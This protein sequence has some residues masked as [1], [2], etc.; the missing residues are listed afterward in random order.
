MDTEQTA[1]KGAVLS[2]PTLFAIDI[3]NF[4]RREK[5]TTFVAMRALR[6]KMSYRILTYV[7]RYTATYQCST[8]SPKGIVVLMAVHV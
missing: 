3:E 7:G 8:V 6:V 4:S 2:G 1:P 5:Q